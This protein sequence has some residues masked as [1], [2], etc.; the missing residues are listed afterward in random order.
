M[1]NTLQ[2]W[3]EINITSLNAYLHSRIK[4]LYTFWSSKKENDIISKGQKNSRLCW[5]LRSRNDDEK[6]KFASGMP[7]RSFTYST[8]F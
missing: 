7:V 5:I 6:R 4:C 2:R 1:N 3:R 8:S